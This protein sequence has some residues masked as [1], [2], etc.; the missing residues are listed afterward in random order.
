MVYS[1]Q[2]LLFLALV[3]RRLDLTHGMLRLSSYVTYAVQT[4]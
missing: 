1:W 4:T 2:M 3:E